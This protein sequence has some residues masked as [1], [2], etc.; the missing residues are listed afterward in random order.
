MPPGTVLCEVGILED[1]LS[2]I[3]PFKEVF[4]LLAACLPLEDRALS[5]LGHGL[6]TAY[7]VMGH[8][9]KG[10][11]TPPFG[12]FLEDQAEGQDQFSAAA[13]LT[14]NCLCYYSSLQI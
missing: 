5:Y 12:Q 13:H 2:I 4:F 1:K 14:S 9:Y 11:W 8:V 3:V 6:W 10:T 7:L